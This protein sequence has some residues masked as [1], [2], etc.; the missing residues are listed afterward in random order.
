MNSSKN[1]LKTSEKKYIAYRRYITPTTRQSD[2]LKIGA[3]GFLIYL[4][5]Y[6]HATTTKY[7]AI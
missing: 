5:T 1:N 6:H 2:R 7:K 3:E 4:N